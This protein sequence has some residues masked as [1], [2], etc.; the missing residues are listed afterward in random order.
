MQVEQVRTIQQRIKDQGLAVSF[1]AMALAVK[2]LQNSTRW[3]IRQVLAAYEEGTLKN[4]EEMHPSQLKALTLAQEACALVNKTRMDKNEKRKAD[5]DAA[6]ARGAVESELKK[7]VPKKLLKSFISESDQ[8]RAS[9]WQILDM[10]LLDKTMQLL[11]DDEGKKAYKALPGAV[12]QQAVAQVRSDFQNWLEALKV[13]G[14]APGAFTGKPKM[15]GYAPKNSY[16][17]VKFPYA[18]THG[19]LI[20]IAGKDLWCDYEKTQALPKAAH[21]AYTKF[22]LDAAIEET[23]KRCGVPGAKP[24]EIR[25]VPKRWGI[26][27]EVVLGWTGDVSDSSPYAQA[28]TIQQTSDNHKKMS[29]GDIGVSLLE[30]LALERMPLSAGA[31]LGL[32]NLI[33]LVY[34]NG[35][36][37]KVVSHS[38]FERKVTKYDKRIDSRQSRIVTDRQKELQRKAAL[39]LAQ[40]DRGPVPLDRRLTKAEQTELR[41]LQADVQNNA[42]L[43]DLRYRRERWIADALHKV[44]SGV[45]K[46]L[47]AKGVQV[48]VIGRNVGW[49]Y[50]VNMGAQGNRRFMGTAHA[51]LIEQLTYKCA[52]VGILVIGTEESYTSK[53]SFAKNETLRS[54]TEKELTTS[55]AVSG[56]DTVTN[57]TKN[58]INVNTESQEVCGVENVEGLSMLVIKGEKRSKAGVRKSVK[59]AKNRSQNAFDTH[60]LMGRWK[61]IHADAN[62]AFNILRKVYCNFVRHKGL[63]SSFELWGLASP[64]LVKLHEIPKRD[65]TLSAGGSAHLHKS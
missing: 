27:L 58:N 5:H 62:G 17:T 30:G 54:Y 40:M 34:T 61:S 25:L 56:V 59:G 3:V 48:L 53:T 28:L 26:V 13:Y 45:V 55:I 51:T 63:S 32:T 8:E 9:A 24:K 2:N 4:L 10:S 31:D 21:N 64:G 44:S 6:V 36:K 7:L 39:A 42:Q 50:E 15:P 20:G 14:K 29:L 22:D 33:T 19:K 49:K 38:R 37:S 16:A 60:G 46:D 35:D 11:L 52:A 18:Q 57:T 23:I 43:I 12:A 1:S 41:T 65:S 47:V